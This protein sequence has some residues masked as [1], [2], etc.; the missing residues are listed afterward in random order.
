MNYYAISGKGE[1]RFTKFFYMCTEGYQ[2][3]FMRRRPAGQKPPSERTKD[4]VCLLSCGG[5]AIAM[6]S[7]SP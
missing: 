1:K 2:W 3:D 4:I 7:G 5:E 6:L